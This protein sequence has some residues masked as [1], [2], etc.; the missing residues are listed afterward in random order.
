L[1]QTRSRIEPDGS[2]G[3]THR[4]AGIWSPRW[5]PVTLGAR[6]RA[7]PR[8]GRSSTRDL[9]LPKPSP[10]Q[11]GPCR[12]ECC[13]SGVCVMCVDVRSIATAATGGGELGT[14]TQSAH[15]QY[16]G[17]T[18]LGL[19]VSAPRWADPVR[20]CYVV[21]V[22]KEQDWGTERHWAQHKLPSRCFSRRAAINVVE[23]FSAHYVRNSRAA[24][25][26]GSIPRGAR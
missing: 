11:T 15:L 10:A 25:C 19:P 7:R 20:S 12:A 16:A 18:V 2:S 13:W 1:S 14:R 5:H 4:G 22:A 3:M 8:S 9:L 23:A 24:R 26:R 17:F 21:K 6:G